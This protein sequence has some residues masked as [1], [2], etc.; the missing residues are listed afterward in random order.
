[1]LITVLAIV[2]HD[3]SRSPIFAQDRV[4]RNGKLLKFYKFR[5]MCV[6]AEAKLEALLTKN[7]MD[8]PVFK[9]KDDPRIQKN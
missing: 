8:G 1:M 2:V 4:G 6:D 7:E 9:I 5:S 3:S